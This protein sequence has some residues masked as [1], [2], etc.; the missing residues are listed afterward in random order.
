MKPTK[1]NDILKDLYRMG[2]TERKSGGGSHR[3]FT[4]PNRATLSIPNTREIPPGTL[5]NIL[6][7]L[8]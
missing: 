8:H 4:A 2:Y 1:I 5:R 7:L 6:K 3:I